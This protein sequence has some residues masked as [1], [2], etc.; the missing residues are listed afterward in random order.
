MSEPAA[1]DRIAGK[2]FKGYDAFARNE[3]RYLVCFV[4]VTVT[5]N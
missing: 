4:R 3:N 5:N 2:V 1:S